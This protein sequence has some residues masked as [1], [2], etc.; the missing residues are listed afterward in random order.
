MLNV[1][2]GR[3]EC[4]G[5]KHHDRFKTTNRRIKGMEKTGRGIRFA[6]GQL[7][8]NV[9]RQRPL[10]WSNKRLYARAPAKKTTDIF[11][12]HEGEHGFDVASQS[13]RLQCRRERAI[14]WR[15]PRL[16]HAPQ[17]HQ[18]PCRVSGTPACIFCRFPVRM[19]WS[20]ADTQDSTVR[21]RKPTYSFVRLAKSQKNEIPNTKHN[22]RQRLSPFTPVASS[23]CTQV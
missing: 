17:N 3:F 15:Y 13:K 11:Y 16:C 21:V 12:L 7:R 20:P 9:G 22:E 5:R 23:P 14:P 8:R 4:A 18:S 2:S 10:P 19:G 1:A 6:L